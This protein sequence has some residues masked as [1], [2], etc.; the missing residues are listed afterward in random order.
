MAYLNERPAGSNASSFSLIVPPPFKVNKRTAPTVLFL[1]STISSVATA[2]CQVF[3]PLKSF[4]RFQ[5]LLAEASML[6]VLVVVSG[7]A[8]AHA[9][10]HAS[11]PKPATTIAVLIFIAPSPCVVIYPAAATAPPKAE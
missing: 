8:A 5:T 10:A 3:N 2:G 1:P 9:P 7:G 11:H 6:T 4:T